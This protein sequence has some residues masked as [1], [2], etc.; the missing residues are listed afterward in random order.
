MPSKTTA[1]TK[2]RTSR[3]ILQRSTM[4][5]WE[6]AAEVTACPHFIPRQAIFSS[7]ARW[8][9][10]V[11]LLQISSIQDSLR[12]FN[13][14]VTR[15]SDL[16]SRSL[17]NTDD[18]SA[19]RNAAQL[20]DL[21]EDTSALSATLKRRIKALEKQGGSGRDGQIRKQQVRTP[22]GQ[23]VSSYISSF[24]RRLWSSP[25]S[26]R[27]SKTTRLSNNS[28]VQSTSSEWRGSSR[29]VRHFLHCGRS[30]I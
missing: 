14:N 1:P 10:L 30:R 20:D 13:D 25:N 6:E 3:T 15:I 7:V 17:N 26:W 16:H 5:L 27:R 4:H 11:F 2:C 22:Q 19:Q 8:L 18:N 29:S 24:R 12:T 9:T 21:V 28:T 23:Y